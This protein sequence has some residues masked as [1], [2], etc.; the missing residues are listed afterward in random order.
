M[1]GRDHSREHDRHRVCSRPH[2]Y[3]P[4]TLRGIEREVAASRKFD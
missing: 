1:S 3:G 4:D 2:D